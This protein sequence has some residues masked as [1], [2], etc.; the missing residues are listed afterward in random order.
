MVSVGQKSALA[1]TPVPITPWFTEELSFVETNL[2]PTVSH[3]SELS[4]LNTED[5][6]FYFLYNGET[7][8]MG[9]QLLFHINVYEDYEGIDVNHNYFS[10]FEHRNKIG[11]N[12]PENTL[13]L[14]FRM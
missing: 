12:R 7:K 6:P 2:P 14:T 11:D 1:C 13:P 9:T 3:P 10:E 8:D 5:S 4:F